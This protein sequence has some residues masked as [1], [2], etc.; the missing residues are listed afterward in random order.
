MSRFIPLLLLLAPA[1]GAIS[2]SPSSDGGSTCSGRPCVYVV[3]CAPDG[4]GTASELQAAYDESR[5]GDT[6]KLQAVSSANNQCVWTAPSE[7][8]FYLRRRPGDSGFITITTT[9]D[10]K[11]PREGTRITPAYKPLMPI[12]QT[13]TFNWATMIV[14]GTASSGDNIKIRGIYFRP[15]PNAGTNQSFTRGFLQIGS[16][17]LYDLPLYEAVIGQPASVG[18]TIITLTGGVWGLAP[19]MK[20]QLASAYGSNPEVVTIASVGASSITL[21]A[22]ITVARAVNDRVRVA[23]DNASVQPD[24]VVIQHCILD[25]GTNHVRIRRLMSLNARS[26]T[27]RDSFFD[28]AW[29]YAPGDSQSIFGFNAPGPYLIENNYIASGSENI[30]LGGQPPSFDVEVESAMIRYNYL[31]HIPERDRH[32]PWQWT[33]GSDHPLNGGRDYG[34]NNIDGNPRLVFATRHVHPSDVQLGNKAGGSKGWFVALNTGIVG[35]VEPDWYSVPNGGTIFDGEPG[36]GVLWRHAGLLNNPEIKNNFEI[37]SARNVTLLYNVFDWS[38]DAIYS[39]GSYN[40]QQSMMVNIKSV[41]HGSCSNDSAVWPECYRARTTGFRMLNNLVRSFPGGIRLMGGQTGKTIAGDYLLKG[42]LFLQTEPIVGI[43]YRLVAIGPSANGA[44]YAADPDFHSVRVEN[45]TWYSPFQRESWTVD[46]DTQGLT[47]GGNNSFRGNILSR[48][49]VV[50]KIGGLRGA[51]GGDGAPGSIAQWPGVAGFGR[52]IIIG[53]PTGA[54]NYPAGSVLSNCPGTAA[55]TENWDYDDPIHGKLLNNIGA[56]LL[57][58]RPTHAWAKRALPDGS[59]IGADV[60]D[61]PQIENLQVSP[62]DRLV[63]LRWSLTS[64]IADIPCA[65]EVNTTPDFA[66]PYAGE[67]AD[68]RK[69]FQQDADTADRN[70]RHNNERMVSIGYAATLS[71]STRY[72]YR[73]QCGGDTRRGVFTTLAATSGPGESTVSRS[74]ESFLAA[75]MDVEYGTWYSRESDS[76]GD[77]G[78]IAATCTEDRMCTATFSVPKGSVAYYRW[79]ERDESGTKLNSGPVSVLTVP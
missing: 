78:K 27:V 61:V 76:L 69:Y 73:L 17:A 38:Y 36:T 68:I 67:L 45:N 10:D 9:E 25:G 66:G 33:Q 40:G 6:I 62:T 34:L 8:G 12:L 3:T 1:F 26:A 37:K 50:H 74:L 75:G 72:Y 2:R 59:D 30:M 41:P 31:A 46:V 21:K 57:Q 24:N 7:L 71:P 53:S 64:P 35:T 44:N 63:L 32:G 56:G 49:G 16:L 18:A 4:T 65:A 28:G 51:F 22:P 11:L 5:R 52:N 13:P 19:D 47:V 42:N 23:T 54:Q 77:G 55:C 48:G 60:S 58:V 14:A 43:P 39:I 29:D 70:I 20:V 15:N 79:I